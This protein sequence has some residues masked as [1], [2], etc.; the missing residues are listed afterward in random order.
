MGKGAKPSAAT[1]ATGLTKDGNFVSGI[2]PFPS[3]GKFPIIPKQNYW[4]GG[5]FMIPGM[6][7]IMSNDV[8]DRFPQLAG[9]FGGSSPQISPN[10]ESPGLYGVPP[11]GGSNVPQK[12][13][14]D[15]SKKNDPFSRLR[16]IFRIPG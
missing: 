13:V 6:G 4:E 8:L 5:N 16:E 11:S 2:T 14:Q 12:P 1:T 15:G 10:F 3:D 7:A 9:L